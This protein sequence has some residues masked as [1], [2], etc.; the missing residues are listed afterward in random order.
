MIGHVASHLLLP[1][2]GSFSAARRFFFFF[3][4]SVINSFTMFGV[5]LI[6]GCLMVEGLLTFSETRLELEDRGFDLVPAFGRR[7]FLGPANDGHR[8]I[9][10]QKQQNV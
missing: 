6:D 5:C 2:W 7:F 8:L 10:T 3:S 1:S 9:A 4:F